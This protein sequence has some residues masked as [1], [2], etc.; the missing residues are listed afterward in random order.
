MFPKVILTNRVCPQRSDR[1]SWRSACLAC[2][3]AGIRRLSAAAVQHKVEGLLQAPIRRTEGSLT[4]S[5]AL[6]PPRRHLQ[7]TPD[8]MRPERRYLQV[9]GLQ[10]RRSRALQGDDTRHPRVHS[11]LSHARA[12]LRLPPHPLLWP[13]RQRPA[14]R[15]H[16]PRSRIALRPPKNSLFQPHR[17][18]RSRFRR[19]SANC[20]VAGM[21]HRIFALT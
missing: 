20:A 5:R 16:R 17:L 12:A 7:S 10:D 13:A 18:A 6:H 15:E 2:R 21:T 3:S 4:L 1:R 14:C 11:P 19:S 9:E 8:R